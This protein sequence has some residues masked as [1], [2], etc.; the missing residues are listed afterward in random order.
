[1]SVI[2][3]IPVN[4]RYRK[5]FHPLSFMKINAAITPIIMVTGVRI[6]SVLKNVFQFLLTFFGLYFNLSSLMIDSL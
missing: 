2:Q 1:M 5:E 4:I 6:F 3:I